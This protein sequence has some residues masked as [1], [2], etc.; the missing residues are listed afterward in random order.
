MK[1]VKVTS[2]GQ[3]TIP[4]EARK[5]LGVDEHTYLEV[6]VDGDEVR[7]RKLVQA[8]PLADED[9]I[10]SLVGSASGDT[11]DASVDH[12]RYLAEGEVARWRESS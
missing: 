6:R 4:Q 5:A 2:K 3:V 9:P 1:V 8:R 12:D 10:W 7:F 11:H